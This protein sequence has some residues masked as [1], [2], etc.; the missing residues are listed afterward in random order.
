MEFRST[1][2]TDDAV[3]AAAADNNPALCKGA[4]GPAV[5]AIQQALVDLGY[6]MPISMAGGVPDGIFGDETAATVKAFQSE[7]HLTVDGIVGRNTMR[8]L[9]EISA[10]EDLCP[11][12]IAME[13]TAS[14][15]NKIVRTPNA[16]RGASRIPA[17]WSQTT[18]MQASL[19][20]YQPSSFL[21]PTRIGQ[22]WLASDSSNRDREMKM[23]MGGTSTHPIGVMLQLL[24]I[25]MFGMAVSQRA[26]RPIRLRLPKT[27]KVHTPALPPVVRSWQ[28][29]ILLAQSIA[30]L[31][32]EE[33]WRQIKYND[34]YERMRD[35]KDRNPSVSPECAEA[36]KEFEKIRNQL[37]QRLNSL[38]GRGQLHPKLVEAANELYQGG[39]DTIGYLKLLAKVQKCFG[40]TMP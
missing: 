23:A 30:I 6:P 32:A 39:K 12:R 31:T 20:V 8:A 33:V 13:E 2:F 29:L 28:Q 3:L 17:L 40:C 10:Y 1:R 14:A 5:E 7:L 26:Q 4:K 27:P 21:P 19:A 38:K 11:M 15:V 9:D 24:F 36:W 35:C 37:L 18:A 22:I 25:A 34:G 16:N